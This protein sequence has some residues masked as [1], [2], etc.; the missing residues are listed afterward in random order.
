MPHRL[1]NQLVGAYTPAYWVIPSRCFL[2][3]I[4]KIRS[5]VHHGSDTFMRFK[6]GE[7]GLS[8]PLALG[9]YQNLIKQ[10]L[11]D[12]DCIV[13]VPLSP[14]KA[15][16]GEIHRTKLLAREVARL[17]SVPVL[18]LLAL[19]HPISKRGLR[20]QLGFSAGQFE[21]NYSAALRC[22]S[23]PEHYRRI[24]LIDDV[25]TEGST[26]RCSLLALN[27]LAP[28]VEVSLATAG[29]MILKAV[30]KD[31]TSLLSST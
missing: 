24:L 14:D 11:V 30:V 19:E 2:H 9:I 21:A 13:P 6:V 20:T 17:L 8:Y 27:K 3:K 12:F 5:A 7:E 1:L 26:L 18:E 10:G 29:Q 23:P 22:D 31:Q 25:C 15:A 4:G 16:A 28:R